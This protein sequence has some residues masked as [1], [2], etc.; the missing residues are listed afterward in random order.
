MDPTALGK[1]EGVPDV[2]RIFD[3]GDLVI[4]DLTQVIHAP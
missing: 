4:Y 2:S 1:F 3:S